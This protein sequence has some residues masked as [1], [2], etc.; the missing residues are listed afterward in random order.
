MDL[1]TIITTLATCVIAYFAWAS[2]Q[3]ALAIQQQEKAHQ[4][5][6]TDL[7]E[8]I[9][10]ATVMGGQGNSG[11]VNTSIETF[12]KHYKGSTPIF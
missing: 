8:A 10:I 9:M 6:L 3:V 5:E 4:K 11:V 12:K 2:H 1:S 7:Y